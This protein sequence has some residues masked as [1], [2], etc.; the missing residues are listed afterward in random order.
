[1]AQANGLELL[2]VTVGKE[3]YQKSTTIS[4][5]KI[6]RSIMQFFLIK[7]LK[8]SSLHSDCFVFSMGSNCI[9]WAQKILLF[10]RSSIGIVEIKWKKCVLASSICLFAI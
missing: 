8:I 5:L 7:K 3:Q 4:F 10:F 6:T 9:I 1:M 2:F